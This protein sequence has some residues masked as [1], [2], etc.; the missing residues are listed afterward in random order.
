MKWNKIFLGNPLGNLTHLWSRRRQKDNFGADR[1]ERGCEDVTRI[2]SAFGHV[3]WWTLVFPCGMEPSS[4]TGVLLYG[5][6][7]N[8]VVY[9]VYRCFLK[10]LKIPF[11]RQIIFLSFMK[12]VSL[13]QG[14]YFFL[15]S[16]NLLQLLGSCNVEWV[17]AEW[18][19]KSWRGCGESFI[20]CFKILLRVTV[21][22]A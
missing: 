19:G 5:Y 1:R 17:L 15:C 16:V 6:S 4:F 2:K 22:H 8:I 10:L 3:Q 9:R 20:V 7:L 18:C 13:S 21:I 14:Q 11:P 12:R